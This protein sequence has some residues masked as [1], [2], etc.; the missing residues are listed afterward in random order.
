M[1]IKHQDYTGKLID[2]PLRE[3]FQ[4]VYRNV[5][6]RKER[7]VLANVAVVWPEQETEPWF[8]LT[9][10]P[11]LQGVK[12]TKVYAKRM[13]IEEYFRDAKSLLLQ[14]HIIHVYTGVSKRS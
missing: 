4:K 12:L 3:G 10:L 9:S 2:L 8:L 11:R 7:P 13:S 5:Q 1:Y 14:R 6:Y